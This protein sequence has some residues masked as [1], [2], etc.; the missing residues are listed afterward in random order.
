MNLLAIDTA[1]EACSAAILSGDGIVERYQLAP[2]EHNR[3]ILPMIEGVLAE[4][5]L[6]PAQLDAIAFG[7]GPGSFTGVRIA[8]GVVQGIALGL[9]LPVVPVSTLAALALD[10]METTHATRA[11]A[12]IDARMQEVYWGVYDRLASDELSLA[13]R[14]CVCSPHQIPIVADDTRSGVGCGS[15]WATY[16]AIITP[17]LDDVLLTTLPDRFPRAGI[18]AR[19]AADMF[20]RGQ[21]VPPEHAMPVYLRDQVAKKPV[22][23]VGIPN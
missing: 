10:A 12:C 1:T 6:V 19:L 5:G 2:R 7:R 14:E 13:E 4:A 23:T 22:K 16:A 8:A 11:F 18:M 21:A 15:G 20:H 3:M 17:Q 9:D